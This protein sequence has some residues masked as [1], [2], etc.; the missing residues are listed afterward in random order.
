MDVLEDVFFG[1]VYQLQD[2]AVKVVAVDDG[3]AGGAGKHGAAQLDGL[4]GKEQPGC[5]E[6]LPVLHKA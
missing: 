3:G 2:V 6:Q 4:V 5:F 1:F